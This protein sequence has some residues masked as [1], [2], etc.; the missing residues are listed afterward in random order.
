MGRIR[1]CATKAQEN[2]DK[3]YGGRE[4]P[5]QRYERDPVQCS[6][7]GGWIGFIQNRFGKWYPIHVFPVGNGWGYY[8]NY[9]NHNNMKA[10]I[11]VCNK[12][13]W[14]Y[15][16]YS[17]VLEAI[18]NRSDLDNTFELY[19]EINNSDEFVEILMEMTPIQRHYG[20]RVLMEWPDGLKDTWGG[21]S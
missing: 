9:G 12:Y 6:R 2:E 18:P 20:G 19:R 8:G 14:G 15:P 4:R 11:H 5:M 1:I 10:E 13:A 21:E 3:M 16:Y 17:D 7:C